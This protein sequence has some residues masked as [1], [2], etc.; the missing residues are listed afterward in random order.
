MR[1]KTYVGVALVVGIVVVIVGIVMWSSGAEGR[2]YA[3]LSTHEVAFLCTTDMATRFHIHPML[4]IVVDGQEQVIPANVGITSTCMHP[5]H[6]HDDTGRL[7]VESP[8][9]RDF[10]LGDF[11]AVW[12]KPFT[13]DQILD[14]R[15]DTAH[16]IRMTVNGQAVDTFED[17]VLHDLDQ[18][19]IRYETI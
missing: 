6:T 14:Y 19:V 15:V 7:H 12:E 1:T 16:T 2:K 4:H 3:D 13:K 18:I 10:T 9:E 17:T 11:F 5:L 8:V